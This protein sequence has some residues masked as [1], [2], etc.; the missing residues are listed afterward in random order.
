[1]FPFVKRCKEDWSDHPDAVIKLKRAGI[2][3][4][5][6]NNEALM[7]SAIES[8]TG[9][10]DILKAFTENLAEFDPLFNIIEP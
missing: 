2:M 6:R 1:M 7:K 4:I 8:V 3:G 9:N 5:A 10:Q